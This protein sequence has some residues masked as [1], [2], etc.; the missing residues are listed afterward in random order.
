[1]TEPKPTKENIELG[2]RIKTI[3]LSLGK[4]VRSFGAMVKPATSGSVVS[5]WER[6]INKPNAERLRSIAKLGNTTVDFLLTGDVVNLDLDI[7]KSPI[8]GL[9]LFAINK[10]ILGFYKSI[11]G[12]SFSLEAFK[13][14]MLIFTSFRVNSQVALEHPAF[15]V[16]F[17]C[18]FFK[19]CQ[20]NNLL[21]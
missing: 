14:L 2:N 10:I 13:F 18:I 11:V 8:T 4:D 6:G 21:S 19:T 17:V 7:F 9:F 12:S 20:F 15:I 1:M 16:V 5:R 3:R